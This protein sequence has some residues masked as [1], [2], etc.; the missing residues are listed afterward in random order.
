[1][2]FGRIKMLK[3]KT[4]RQKLILKLFQNGIALKGIELD[5]IIKKYNNFEMKISSRLQKI[6]EEEEEFNK[7]SIFLSNEL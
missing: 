4:Y 5:S 3:D 1:M 7:F 2:R 6:C